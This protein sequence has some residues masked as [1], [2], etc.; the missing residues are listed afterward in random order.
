MGSLDEVWIQRVEQIILKNLV[1]SQFKNNSLA[2]AVHCSERQL[3][4]QLNELTGYTPHQF[5]REIRLHLARVYLENH[6]YRTVK[7]VSYAVGFKDT[8]HFS[9][10]FIQRFGV[11]PASFL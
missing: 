3:Y 4:R 2:D 10:L 5:I 8:V 11:Y 1:N 9:R 6:R 7:E